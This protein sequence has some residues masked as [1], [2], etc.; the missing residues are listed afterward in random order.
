MPV[1]M[2]EQGYRFEFYASDRDERPHIHVKK[3]GKHAKI[4][5]QPIVEI[6]FSR[7]YKPHEVNRILA[8]VQENLESLLEA[9]SGFF[10]GAA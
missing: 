8:L 10:G 1:V 9:W 3:N 2:R 5:L 7:H 4:W 6:Q